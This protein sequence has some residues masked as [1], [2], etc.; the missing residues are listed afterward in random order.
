MEII[1]EILFDLVLELV[2]GFGSDVM[3]NSEYTLNWP[4]PLRIFL[5]VVTLLFF[6]AVIIGLIVLGIIFL[7]DG[8]L[9]VGILLLGVGLLFAVM[10]ILEFR[11]E[12]KKI[13]R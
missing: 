13:R 1:F 6:L 7:L 2:I 8:N 10:M 4:K 9:A 3:E 11:K 5:A 12:Y